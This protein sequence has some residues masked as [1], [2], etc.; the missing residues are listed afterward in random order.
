L[1]DKF[2]KL[3]EK[4]VQSEAAKKIYLDKFK[5]CE[6]EN[7]MLVKELLELRDK[8]EWT[9]KENIEIRLQRAEKEKFLI[10]KVKQ[11][12]QKLKIVGSSGEDCEGI[13]KVG[14]EGYRVR[15]IAKLTASAEFPDNTK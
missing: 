11:T 3:N 8:V 5:E 9:A 14:W 2:S 15:R 6:R 10:G 12:E 4:H 13:E 7:K 1:F